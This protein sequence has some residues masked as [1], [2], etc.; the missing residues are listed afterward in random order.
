MAFREKA[1]S[2]FLKYKIA[3]TA[4]P[5]IRQSTVNQTGA[6]VII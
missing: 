5:A 6:A 2:R 4:A 1:E 3:E